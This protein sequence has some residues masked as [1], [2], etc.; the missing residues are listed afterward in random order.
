MP[1]RPATPAES[2]EPAIDTAR[3][4]ALGQRP[5][6]L[7]MTRVFAAP[8]R[9]VFEAWTTSANVARW[10]APRPLTMARCELDFR[11]GGAF[12]FVMQAPDGTEYP[13]EGAFAEM[14]A[15][16]R[17]VFTGLVHE[18]NLSVTTLL[19]S[20]R[21]GETTLAVRQSYTIESAAT[22]GAHLGWTATLDQL[23]E[24]LTVATARDR[25]HHRS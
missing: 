24:H 13:F 7:R 20:E 23:A 8:R 21:D 11:P 17:I 2:G 1:E 6:D 3:P 25:A 4:S 22:R 12:R 9:A 19:F 18:G 16:E 5:P 14:I 10:F 15:P